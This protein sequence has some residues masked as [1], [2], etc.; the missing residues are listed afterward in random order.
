V[1]L[2]DRDTI[3]HQ[4]LTLSSLP[5]SLVKPSA[6]QLPRSPPAAGESRLASRARICAI[7]WNATRRVPGDRVERGADIAS[8]EP[9]PGGQLARRGVERRGMT[10]LNA[11]P[12]LS[13][14][15]VDRQLR[16]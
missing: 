7:T 16:R 14:I 10:V 11:V 15:R 4:A 2:M 3:R 13:L 8:D 6:D 5:P 1:T 9:D 12:C